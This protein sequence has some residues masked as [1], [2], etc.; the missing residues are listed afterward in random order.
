[1]GVESL[2]YH[3][4]GVIR[5]SGLYGQPWPDMCGPKGG[6][7]HVVA[8]RKRWKSKPNIAGSVPANAVPIRLSRACIMKVKTDL[9][10][11]DPGNFESNK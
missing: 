5:S 4:C 2:M 1:M 7:R 6:G 10:N 9:L 3:H 8:S 11:D